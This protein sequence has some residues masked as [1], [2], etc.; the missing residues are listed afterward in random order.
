MKD[1]RRR[2]AWRLNGILYWMERKPHFCGWMSLYSIVFCLAEAVY[3]YPKDYSREMP[4]GLNALELGLEWT[5][6]E[7]EDE[8]K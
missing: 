8:I 7:Y 1:A 5:G 3:P 2:L 4:V 6:I